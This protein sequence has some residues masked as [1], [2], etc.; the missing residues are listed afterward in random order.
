MSNE[1]IN[2]LTNSNIFCIDIDEKAN[3]KTESS[4]EGSDGRV[5][6][7]NRLSDEMAIDETTLSDNEFVTPDGDQ[8]LI[9]DTTS[10]S[11]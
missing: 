10:S 4:D 8:I 11:Q 7:S 1:G 2:L 5:L 9:I 6:N 3:Q